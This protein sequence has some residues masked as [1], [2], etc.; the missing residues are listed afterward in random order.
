MKVCIAG[1]GA[2]GGLFAGWLG[3]KLP[4]AE[5][6]LS[7]LARGATLAALKGQGLQL[8]DAGGA[9]TVALRASDDASV[10]GPQ[11]LVVLA[12][13]GPALPAMAAQLPPLLGPHTTVLVAMNGVP[14]WFFDHASATPGPCAGLRLGAVDPGDAVRTAIPTQ[15][16]LGCVVHVSAAAPQ[17]GEVKHVN[18]N[19]LI[20]GEPA[21]GPSA[22][23]DATAK[24]LGRAGFAITTSHHI[25]RDI[26]F[27]LWG[28]MTMNPVSAITQAPCDQILDDPLVRG[29]CSAV[30][31]EANAIGALF[32]C[33]I[34]QVPEQRHAVTRKL[35]RFKTSMLQDLEAGRALEID[36][37]VT[38]VRD[39][40]AHLGLATPNIDALLGLVRLLGR[41]RGL[42][43]P[44]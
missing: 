39:I 24:L 7:A 15:Q 42:Y 20:L 16:V 3:T 5:L 36:A 10:L 44:G 43:P 27:K 18:G 41:G 34:D 40:G 9:R 6:Q 22:R 38:V 31:L 11:D 17:P 25:Q 2:I 32:A 30:M 13:K 28:N 35:G 4:T 29:F 37:L 1:V 21:G 19:G 12:V 14:W 8:Q 23:L 33:G 26:W